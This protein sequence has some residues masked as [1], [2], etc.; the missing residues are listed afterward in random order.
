MAPEGTGSHI[1]E[2][3]TLARYFITDVSKIHDWF[4]SWN[5]S[6]S[7]GFYMSRGTVF[8]SVFQVYSF[9]GIPIAGIATVAGYAGNAPF[10]QQML[11][12]NISRNS[13]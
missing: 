3:N 4:N 13:R 10:E 9:A 7:T 1:Y 5:Y 12:Y 6:S 8:D 11:Y 2:G